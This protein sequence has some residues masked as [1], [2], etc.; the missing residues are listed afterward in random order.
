MQDITA[1]PTDDVSS[2]GRRHLSESSYETTSGSG[3]SSSPDEEGQ[4][5][6]NLWHLSG[7]ADGLAQLPIEPTKQNAVL[8]QTCKSIPRNQL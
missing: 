8:V 7:H 2:A 1:E 4:P 3:D 6:Y 5:K